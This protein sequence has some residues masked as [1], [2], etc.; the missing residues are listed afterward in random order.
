VYKAGVDEHAPVSSILEFTDGIKQ[1]F[2]KTCRFHI[3]GYGDLSCKISE[4]LQMRNYQ[5]ERITTYL[6]EFRPVLNYTW[7]YLLCNLA[8]NFEGQILL[9]T[10]HAPP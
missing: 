6:G 9:E 10:R 3:P 8:T 7:K 2:P 4:D 1:F 5:E